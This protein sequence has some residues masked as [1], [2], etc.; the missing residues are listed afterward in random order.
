MTLHDYQTP[1][2]KIE[3]P[4]NKIE[5]ASQRLYPRKW[6]GRGIGFK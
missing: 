3:I 4:N 1:I 2:Y 5:N 6:R